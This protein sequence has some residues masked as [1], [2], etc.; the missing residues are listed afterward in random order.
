MLG[1]DYGL[2]RVGLAASDPLGLTAQPLE[3]FHRTGDAALIAHLRQLVEEKGIKKVVLGLP[4]NMDGTR[5]PMTEEVERFES[6][7]R[8]GLG[9]PIE[10][11]DERL[12]SWQAEQALAAS[13]LPKK[14]RWEKAR[15]DRLAAQ[16]LLQSYLDANR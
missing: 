7:L 6:K 3:T 16:I 5:S 4:T 13:G 9:L 14:M 8:E 11:W 1:I 12:T 15:I 10:F 2:K